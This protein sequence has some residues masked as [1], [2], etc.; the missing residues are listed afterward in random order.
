[1]LA[2]GIASLV[3][4]SMCMTAVI[5][6]PLGII[7]W[8]IGY[9]DLRKMRAGIMDPEGKGNTQGGYICGIIGTV[10]NVLALLAFVGW[11]MLLVGFSAPS[12]SGPPPKF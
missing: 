7:A 4:G 8:V 1:V 9:R 5:G 12:P 6:L 10:L 2:L 11:I 3:L